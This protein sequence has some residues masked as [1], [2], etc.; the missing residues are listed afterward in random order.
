MNDNSPLYS[1]Y[2]CLVLVIDD[3]PNSYY[4]SKKLCMSNSIYK[5]VQPFFVVNNS[6]SLIDIT[7]F[8]YMNN[9]IYKKNAKVQ[10][11]SCRPI[12]YLQKFNLNE[13]TLEYEFTLNFEKLINTG[14][15]IEDNF[16]YES[17]DGFVVKKDNKLYAKLFSNPVVTRPNS[18]YATIS[19]IYIY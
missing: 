4:I 18:S 13:S 2:D 16:T 19:S 9:N 1:K 7:F 10:I 11:Y 15:Y 14:T 12:D 6:I 17:D 5:Y 8:D 3:T